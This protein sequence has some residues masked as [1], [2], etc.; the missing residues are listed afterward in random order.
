MMA[1]GQVIYGSAAGIFAPQSRTELTKIAGLSDAD[2]SAFYF[3]SVRNVFLIGYGNGNIEIAPF[4]ALAA[5]SSHANILITDIKDSPR[6]MGRKI[7]RFACAGALCA[8]AADFGIVQIDADKAEIPSDFTIHPQGSP[9]AVSDLTA[10]GGWWAAAADTGLFFCQMGNPHWFNHQE[11]SIRLAGGSFARLAALGDTLFALS[12]DGFLLKTIDR[13]RFDTIYSSVEMI[14]AHGGK[15]WIAANGSVFERT[16]GQAVGIA[17][18]MAADALFADGYLWLADSRTGLWRCGSSECLEQTGGGLPAQKTLLL[19]HNQ[20]RVWAAG[21]G[22]LCGYQNLQWRCRTDAP[23]GAPAAL[24]ADPRCKE[25]AWIA[26]S[27]NVFYYD[28]S[29]DAF[30]PQNPP[31]PCR[32]TAMDA[33]A[34]GDLLVGCAQG[35]PSVQMFTAQGAWI[36][37]SIPDLTAAP[38][39]SI[40]HFGNVFR[41]ITDDIPSRVFA[42]QS[43]PERGFSYTISLRNNYASAHISAYTACADRSGELWL[44]TN[45]GAAAYTAGSAWAEAQGR[46]VSTESDMPGY[47]A[48]LLEYQT[49]TSIVSDGGSRK[50]LGTAADGAFAVSAQG[51]ALLRQFGEG[52]SPLPSNQ[53]Y[54]I[55]VDALTG[56][57]FFATAKGVAAFRAD[58][59]GSEQSFESVKIYPNPVRPSSQTLT[60]SGLVQDAQIVITDAAGRLIHS[61]QANGGTYAWDLRLSIG[62]G[63]ADTGVYVVFMNSPDGS[64]REVGKVAIIN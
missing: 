38:I 24:A 30:L 32:I 27:A 49:I 8:A 37:P 33:A 1:Q 62:G 28:G 25:C 21:N 34:G 12:K 41:G 64:Q 44:G 35:Q 10:V 60:I 47:A 9:M 23:I 14:A 54:S 15:L 40:T 51:G 58:A 13:Q 50:W 31:L 63:R 11:W 18:R 53:V 56:D 29:N 26:D 36:T 39:R 46:R 17:G 6:A 61:G 48:Y 57:V 42:Y 2:A 52:S 7:N 5:L 43:A 55:A 19:A 59:S 4:S 45:V 16:T 20:G 3:D 22:F